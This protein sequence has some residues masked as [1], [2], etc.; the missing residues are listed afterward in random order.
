MLEQVPV[1]LRSQ[2]VDCMI[3]EAD[4]RIKDPVYG[5][6]GVISK[7][8][9]Q[10]MIVQKEIL[11]VHVEIALQNVQMQQGHEIDGPDIGLG[12]VNGP[13]SGDEIG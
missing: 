7:L 9:E 6:A 13:L 5:S 2:T 12:I 10:I 1:H 11:K 3:L 8:Q 4:T